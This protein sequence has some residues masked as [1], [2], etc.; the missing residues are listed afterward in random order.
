[1]DVCCAVILVIIVFHSILLINNSCKYQDLIAQ[2]YAS[3]SVYVFKDRKIRYQLKCYFCKAHVICS[4][5]HIFVCFYMLV[6]M[7]VTGFCGLFLC[8]LCTA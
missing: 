4:I 3:V 1:M 2:Q 5:L 8:S 7:L 6:S